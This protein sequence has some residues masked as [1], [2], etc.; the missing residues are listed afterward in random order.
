MLTMRNNE[1]GDELRTIG[2]IGGTVV[3]VERLLEYGP[4]GA[5]IAAV[6][7]VTAFAFKN[8][9]KVNIETGTHNADAEPGVRERTLSKK[10]SR[11][12][13]KFE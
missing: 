10:G 6:L 9:L 13:A 4:V 1:M 3:V 7:I 2:T 8:G 5:L 12:K 11:S